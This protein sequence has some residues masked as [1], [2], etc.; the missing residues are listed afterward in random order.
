MRNN[1]DNSNGG[2]LSPENKSENT[3]IDNND[4]PSEKSSV[5]EIRHVLNSLWIEDEYALGNLDNLQRL[6]LHKRN[7]Y[8]FN[9]KF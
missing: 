1:K 2:F 9:N 4:I 7:D 8:K 5:D 6:E 3:Y